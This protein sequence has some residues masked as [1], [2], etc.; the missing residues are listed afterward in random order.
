[1]KVADKVSIM[2]FPLEFISIFTCQYP[3]E[4]KDP[5]KTQTSP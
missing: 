3:K 4:I 2:V 1:M 5:P